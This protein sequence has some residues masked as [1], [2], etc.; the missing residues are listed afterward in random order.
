MVFGCGC[1]RHGG[2]VVFGYGRGR[3]CHSGGLVAFW[4]CEMVSLWF[5]GVVVVDDGGLVFLGVVVGDGGELVV[6][7]CGR[8]CRW[9]WSSL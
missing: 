8:R 6:F 2:L 1:G 5:L 3:R 7:G 9:V 4:G